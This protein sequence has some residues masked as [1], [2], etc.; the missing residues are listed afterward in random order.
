M[1][2]INVVIRQE[3]SSVSR[4]MRGIDPQVD[5]DW[6]DA[7]VGPSDPVCLCLN[8]LPHLVEICELFTLTV[9][10]L[11]M[12]WRGGGR[13]EEFNWVDYSLRRCNKD[14]KSKHAIFHQ[15]CCRYA[16]LRHH[17]KKNCF[18]KAIC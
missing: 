4:T 16:C 8:L 15:P 13:N 7:L 5:G 3:T 17:V 12:F 6:R 1:W 18:P 10:E 11:C 9:E 14:V 2:F